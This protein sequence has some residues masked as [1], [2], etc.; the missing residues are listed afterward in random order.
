MPALTPS[1]T[2][3]AGPA[4][5][6]AHAVHV[7]ALTPPAACPELEQAAP[8]AAAAAAGARTPKA[9]KARQQAADALA[10]ALHGGRVAKRRSQER[11]LGPAHEAR[12]HQPPSK[13]GAKRPGPGP[14]ARR[15]AAPCAATAPQR[16]GQGPARGAAKGQGPR[17]A[18]GHKAAAAAA[19]RPHAGAGGAALPQGRHHHYAG[20]MGGK[21]PGQ[22]QLRQL[23]PAMPGPPLGPPACQPPNHAAPRYPGSALALQ[24]LL[25]AAP[26]PQ[27]RT[28]L[29]PWGGC[30]SW[31]RQG[32]GPPPLA[33][34]LGRTAGAG[35]C[36]ESGLV[37]PPPWPLP[38]RAAPARSER[39][40]TSPPRPCLPTPAM[41]PP[42]QARRRRPLP[43]RASPSRR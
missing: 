39:A 24:P 25:A 37:L 34:H 27:S 12:Q 2:A 3:A 20:P 38:C 32:P 1:P 33:W 5:H 21:A 15:A 8:A 29:M 4:K 28:A 7:P 13:A 31:L 10:L 23:L 6:A 16:S 43:T 17:A 30:L 9:P 36:E 26:P 22:Q 19:G 42:P 40:P 41:L 35:G 11:A 14:A 18:H